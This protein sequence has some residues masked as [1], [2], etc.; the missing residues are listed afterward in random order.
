[1][2]TITFCIILGGVLFILYI[3]LDK[4]KSNDGKIADSDISISNVKKSLDGFTPIMEKSLKTGYT[5]KSIEKQLEKYL[6]TKYKTVTTQYNLES[7]SG[8]QIDIDLGRGILGIEIKI[9][10]QILK[11]A[12]FDRMQGQVMGYK[13]NYKKNLILL[14][15]GENEDFEQTRIQDIERFCTEQDVEVMGKIITN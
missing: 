6:R 5:E 2:D 11:Q 13:K 15:C 4:S 14:I 10:N 12:N 9:A 7:I 8:S 1:M 3:L